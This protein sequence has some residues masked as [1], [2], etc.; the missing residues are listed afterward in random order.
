MT[1]P[2][3]W[4]GSNLGSDAKT[5]PS[6]DHGG[7]RT[8]AA[9]LDP[10]FRNSK[11]GQ[12]NPKRQKAQPEDSHVHTPLTPPSGA[13]KKVYFDFNHYIKLDSQT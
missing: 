6:P 4:R 3:T 10:D 1:C 2:W 5:T 8:C 9:E 11:P 7:R 13:L 12:T